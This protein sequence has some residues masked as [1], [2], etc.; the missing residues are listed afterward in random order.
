MD[1]TIEERT[2]SSKGYRTQLPASRRAL[3]ET[4]GRL[5]LQREALSAELEIAT[6]ATTPIDPEL[7]DRHDRDGAAPRSPLA[8]RS[9]HAAVADAAVAACPSRTKAIAT[10]AASVLDRR[11]WFVADAIATDGRL[12]T[13]KAIARQAIT[14]PAQRRRRPISAT[15]PQGSF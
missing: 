13:A 5:N 2:P 12:R 7:L 8:I 9:S 3:V 11:R 1:A 10:L 15:T 4:S 14:S 6:A